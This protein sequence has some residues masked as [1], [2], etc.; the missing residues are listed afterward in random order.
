MLGINADYWMNL[1]KVFVVNS[2]PVVPP[3]VPMEKFLHY[4][5]CATYLRLQ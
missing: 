1:T 2:I 3:F 5:L 4:P